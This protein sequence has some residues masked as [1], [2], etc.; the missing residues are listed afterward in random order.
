MKKRWNDL[1]MLECMDCGK[2]TLV[3]DARLRIYRTGVCGFCGGTLVL[4]QKHNA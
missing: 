1:D 2:H 4:F 3:V